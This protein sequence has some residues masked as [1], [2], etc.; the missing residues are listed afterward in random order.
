MEAIFLA[1]IRNDSFAL[2]VE[3]FKS[4]VQVTAISHLESLELLLIEQ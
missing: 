4:N 3:D 1:N 2:G